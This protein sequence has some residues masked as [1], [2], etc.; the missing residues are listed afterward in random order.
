[1]RKSFFRR[2]ALLKS[3]VLRKP[4]GE[5]LCVEV[6]SGF[7]DDSR[8]PQILEMESRV[9]DFDVTGISIQICFT[10]HNAKKDFRTKRLVD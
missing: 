7:L 9:S 1:M 10:L 3:S 5:S 2:G 4:V 6:V 8:G